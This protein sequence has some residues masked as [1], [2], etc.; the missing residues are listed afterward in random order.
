MVGP[1]VEY[2]G[3]LT[4]VLFLLFKYMGV[5]FFI[6]IFTGVLR[7]AKVLGTSFSVFLGERIVC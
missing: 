2:V 1:Q 7:V 3:V 6:Y 4:L 5:C